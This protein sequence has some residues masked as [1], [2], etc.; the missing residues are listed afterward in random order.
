[1]VAFPAATPVTTPDVFTVAVPVEL[2]DHVPPV[3]ELLRVVVV[4]GQ[5]LVDPVIVAGIGLTV[6]TAVLKQPVPTV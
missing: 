4:P 1:M 6:T 3:V 2:V 5:T